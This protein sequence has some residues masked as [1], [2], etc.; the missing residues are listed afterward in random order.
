LEEKKEEG[1]KNWSTKFG[2]ELI[3]FFEKNVSI[4]VNFLREGNIV[5]HSFI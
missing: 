2:K 5:R 3:T 1:K 4:F